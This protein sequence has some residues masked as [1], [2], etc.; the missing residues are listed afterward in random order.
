MSVSL[1]LQ[2]DIDFLHGELIQ[3]DRVD[4]RKLPLMKPPKEF[5]NDLISLCVCGLRRPLALKIAR[6]VCVWSLKYS[7]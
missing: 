2:H 4:P 6:T 7:S 1:L 5:A 3:T